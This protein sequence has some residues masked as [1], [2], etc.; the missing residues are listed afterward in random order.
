MV[1]SSAPAGLREGDHLIT[2]ISHTSR[3][4]TLSIAAL[5][6]LVTLSSALALLIAA[7]SL[8]PLSSPDG[9]P[10]GLTTVPLS[11]V[12][13]HADSEG[14][15]ARRRGADSQPENALHLAFRGSHFEHYA[16][17]SHTGPPRRGGGKGGASTGGRKRRSEIYV[18]W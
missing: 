5:P 6:L 10:A 14:S 12:A 4:L 7:V 15:P 3:N 8:A 9:F 16:P 2:L 1:K 11:S 17:A 13:T 18:F